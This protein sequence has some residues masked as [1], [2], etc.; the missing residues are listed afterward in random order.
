MQ[1]NNK[2]LK[3][4]S[5]IL[6]L[7]FLLFAGCSA[8]CGKSEQ[9]EAARNKSIKGVHETHVAD[10]DDYLIDNGK[11]D[12]VLVIPSEAKEYEVEAAELIQN[13][14]FYSTSANLEIINDSD[15]ELYQNKKFISIGNTS[16]FCSAGISIPYD[17]FLNSGFRLITKN[18][19]LFISGS[20]STNR[21]GTFY[22]ATEFLS[23]MIGLEVYAADE[24]NFRYCKSLKMKNFDVT[25]IPEFDIRKLDFKITRSDISYR[26]MLRLMDYQDLRLNIGSSHSHFTILPPLK[27]YND[28]EDWYAGRKNEL[29]LIDEENDNSALTLQLCLSNEEM[30]EEFS[31]QVALLFKNNPEAELIHLGIMDNLEQC[32]CDNCEQMKRDYNTTYSGLNI[33]FSNRVARRVT[34]LVHE[35]EPSRKLRFQIFAYNNS[36]YPPVHLEKGVYVPDCQE[37]MLDDNVQVQFCGVNLELTEAIDAEVNKD[38]YQA[39]QNWQL[40]SKNISIWHYGANFYNLVFAIKDWD[41]FIDTS[42][43][44]SQNGVSDYYVQGAYNWMSQPWEEL[45][46]YVKSKLMWNL[47]LNYDDL[48]KDFIDNYYGDAANYIYEA[49][50]V[51]CGYNKYIQVEKDFPGGMY[52]N[53]DNKEYW[54]FAYVETMRQ[55]YEKAFDSIKPLES[56]DKK[57]YDLYKNRIENLYLEN[58]YMQ[59]NYYISEYHKDYALSAIDQFEAICLRNNIR[60][61]SEEKQ[62]YPSDYVSK[63]RAVYA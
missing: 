31:Q 54:S 46:V 50:K 12:Y 60:D 15:L 29:I 57:Q 11:S 17:E 47:S 55:I 53:I 7:L 48:A 5:V 43:I 44:Y 52:S 23:E 42:Y 36:F 41:V 22:G 4:T 13:Y 32:S 37:V 45:N 58:L 18:N 39:L 28:H 62:K 27:Y 8:S 19:I 2:L 51:M 33:I 49:Y 21:Y 16:L 34:E 35:T 63:W 20:L 3:L 25:E 24:I 9:N 1:V 14:I 56:V 30:L 61:L 38:I 6:C 40:L 26:K 59:L 10:R